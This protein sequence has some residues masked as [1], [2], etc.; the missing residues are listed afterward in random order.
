M[1]MH[2]PSPH[3]SWRELACHDT[4]HTPYPAAWR[5]TRAVILATE[6]ERVRAAVG[7]PLV[8]GSAYR[9]ESW[10]RSVGGARNSQHV[11]GR[12]LDLYP[13]K[14]WSVERLYQIV[15]AIAAEPD[16][17]IWAIGMYPSFIHFDVRPARADGQLT[18][19]HGARAWAEVKT[20]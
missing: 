1:T 6:F 14:T 11:Q 12:A 4:A 13:P 3:L 7:R 2:G 8:I 16:S 15:R 20:V 18:V 17:R 5:E 19:W 10:N 9:T